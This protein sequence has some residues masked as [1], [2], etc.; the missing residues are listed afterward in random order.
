MSREHLKARAKW[1]NSSAARAEGPEKAL[2]I[3]MS[4][5]LD[6]YPGGDIEYVHKP[7]DLRGI[8]GKRKSKKGRWGEHGIVPEGMIVNRANGRCVFVE[9]KRQGSG[10]NAHERACKYMMPGVVA[11]M[12]ERSGHAKPIIPMWWIFT[13]DIAKDPWRKQEIRHWFKGMEPQ[14]LFWPD[15]S[16]YERLIAHFEEH[17]KGMLL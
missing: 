4:M 7:K 9:M 5:H 13:D 14:L 8:Y 16:D 15:W 6:R 17:I 11:S 3:T 2:H 10:G 1:Q 12:R